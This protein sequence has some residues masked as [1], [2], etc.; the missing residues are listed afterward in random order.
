[1]TVERIDIDSSEVKDRSATEDDFVISYDPDTDGA[2][3]V[4]TDPWSDIFDN[5]LASKVDSRVSTWLDENEV[6][7]S[8]IPDAVMLDSEFTAAAVRVLLGYTAQQLDDAFNNATISDRVITFTQLDGSSATLTLPEDMAEGVADGV[9]TGASFNDA[10]TEIT[11]TV[12]GADDFTISVPELLRRGDTLA[13][14]NSDGTAPDASDNQG[15]VLFSRNGVFQSINHGEP[16]KVVAF[17][18]YGPTRSQP[19]NRSTNENNYGGSVANPPHSTIG[20]YAVNA[21]LWDRGSS[22]WIIKPS[23]SATS[24]STY[25]GPLYWHH[26][27]LFTDETQAALHVSQASDVGTRIVIYGHG[28]SQ[29]PYMVTG[30]T[31]PAADDWQWDPIGLTPADVRD[32]ADAQIATHNTATDAHQDIRD[33]IT[34]SV[35]GISVADITSRITTHNTATDAHA[36]IRTEIDALSFLDID[37]YSSSATYNRG[38][39]NSVV[40]HDNKVWIYI[41]SQRNTNHDPEDHPQYWWLLDTPI[42]VLNHDSAVVTHWRSGNIFLTETGQFRY[43][44]AT[45]SSSP[46]DIISMHTGAD[47]EFIWLNEPGGGGA[48]GSSTID[49]LETSDVGGPFDVDITNADRFY[50]STI[51]MPAAAD[52]ADGDI[53]EVSIQ[54]RATGNAPLQPHRFLGKEWKALVALTSTEQSQTSFSSASAAKT[55]TTFLR[56]TSSSG[57]QSQRNTYVAKGLDGVSLYVGDNNNAFDA[58]VQVWKVGTVSKTIIGT[59]IEANPS[60]TDGDDLTRV[61]IGGTNYNIPSSDGGGGTVVSDGTLSGDGTS[62]SPLTVANPFLDADET[63]LDGIDTGATDDQTGAEIATIYQEVQLASAATYDA[64][65]NHITLTVAIHPLQGDVLSFEVPDYGSDTGIV[66][67][68]TNNGSTNSGARDIHNSDGDPFDVEDLT[69]GRIIHAQLHASNWVLLDGAVDSTLADATVGTSY[70]N[71]DS[72]SENRP[73]LE[74]ASMRCKTPMAQ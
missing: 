19:P 69:V 73:L 11:V 23:S 66:S 61:D 51:D 33:D 30:F 36:D 54:F 53:F 7:I 46:A 31:A 64:N 65:A 34:A 62:G 14:L 39:D 50:D 56:Y 29:K 25:S 47:Q 52:I 38:S 3:G 4:K 45:I 74:L 8:A 13:K 71:A 18:E 10:G 72:A 40:T 55:I 17:L 44:T 1:M 22:V 58:T 59:E 41:S 32:V 15:K 24:W 67:L 21:I 26:G 6:P 57:G 16:D 37:P 49:V 2:S 9:A 63:K 28:A 5:V 42:R 27:D 68:R 43:C 60:G 35:S 20:T 48:M 12:D 70:L